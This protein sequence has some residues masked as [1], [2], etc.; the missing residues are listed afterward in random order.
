MPDINWQL[1]QLVM[2]RA[3]ILTEIDVNNRNYTLQL[4]E[5]E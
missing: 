2:A 5:Q 1:G 3:I 4:K